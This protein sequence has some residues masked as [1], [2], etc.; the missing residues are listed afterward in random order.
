ME[1]KSFFRRDP[2]TNTWILVAPIRSKR[3]TG[4][5]PNACPFC[6]GNEDNTPSP[7]LFAILKDGRFVR[8]CHLFEQQNEYNRKLV[9]EEGWKIRMF[10]NKFKALRIEG[11]L[12]ERGVSIYKEMDGIGTHEVLV[13]HPLHLPIWEQDVEFIDL[14]LLALQDRN[15]DLKGDKRFKFSVIFKNYGENAGASIEHP[16]WQLMCLPVVPRRMQD[17]LSTAQNYYT[18]NHK[19]VFC[20]TAR[21][22][23]LKNLIV[24]ENDFFIAIVNFVSRFPYEVDVYLK[25][26]DPDIFSFENMCEKRRVTLAVIL[27]SVLYKMKVVIEDSLKKTFHFNVG[28]YNSPWFQNYDTPD[29]FNLSIKQDFHWFLKIIPRITK[30]AGFELI[31]GFYINTTLPEDAAKELRSVKI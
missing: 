14:S 30:L 16:H 2:F 4:K 12:N 1:E 20:E 13:E 8:V 27:K 21:D 15:R 6:P 31:T 5:K 28:L 11:E 24:E 22:P 26:H 17:V 3:K 10:P 7:E 23:V 9:K 18:L 29:C 19:C 25:N